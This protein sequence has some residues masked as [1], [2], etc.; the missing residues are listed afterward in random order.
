MSIGKNIRRLRESQGMSQAD[1]AITAGVTDK[2]V[3]TWESDLKIPRMKALRQIAA[4]FGVRLSQII[5]D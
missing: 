4:H 1:L 2:A 5:E 3:S